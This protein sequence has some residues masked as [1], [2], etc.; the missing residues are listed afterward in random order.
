MKGCFGWVVDNKSF[1]DKTVDSIVHCVSSNL[2]EHTQDTF[3]ENEDFFVLSDDDGEVAACD[4]L[5]VPSHPS[6]A[7]LNVAKGT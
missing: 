5:G 2:I 3:N 7:G 4:S 1:C 6:N